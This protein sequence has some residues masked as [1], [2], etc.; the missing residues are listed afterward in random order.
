MNRDRKQVLVLGAVLSG[1]SVFISMAAMLVVGK[2]LTHYFDAAYVGVFALLLIGAD[3]LNIFSGFGLHI[4]FPKLIAATPRTGQ[5]GIIAAGLTFQVLVCAALSLVLYPL[6]IL[7]PGGQ[8]FSTDPAWLLLWP[9]L[10]ILPPLFAVGVLREVVMSA[11]AGLNRYGHRAA[12]IITASLAQVVLA[13]ITLKVLHGG[14]VALTIGTILSYGIALFWMVLA[15]PRDARRFKIAWPVYRECVVFS[16]PLYFNQMLTFFYQRLDTVLITGLFG[17]AVG[18]IY[19]MAKRIPLLVSRV[20]TN[21]LVPYLPTVSEMLANGKK[22]DAARLLTRAISLV[23]FAGYGSMF[24]ILLFQELIIR[25][26]FTPE[27]LAAT[28]ALGLLLIAICIHIQ[29]G[30]I[31]QSLVALGTPTVVTVINIG[32]ALVSVAANV[33]LLPRL[34]LL[35]AGWA[36]VLAISVSMVFHVIFLFRRGLHFSLREAMKPQ[37]SMLI[38]YSVLFLGNTPFYRL[39]ALTIF[40]TLCLITS[41]ITFRQMAEFS[42]MVLPWKRS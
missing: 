9:Y 29:T 37:I 13:Y 17:A 7:V 4:A 18:G 19:D 39:S 35:G 24:A 2:I 41:V 25:I 8:V 22:E 16:S 36:A 40:V 31:G 32:L 5:S 6:W 27:Y 33:I 28:P 1:S 3:F 26:L 10:W 15:L 38:A 23:A 30:L 42:R 34:G 20:L 14:I 12:G 21:T 11:L